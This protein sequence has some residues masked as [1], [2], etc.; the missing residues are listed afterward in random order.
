[1]LEDLFKK[2]FQIRLWDC[3]VNLPRGF[4]Q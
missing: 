2:E 1:M 4:T 3:E